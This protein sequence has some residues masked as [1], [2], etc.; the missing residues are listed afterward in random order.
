[1][2]RHANPLKALRRRMYSGARLI[3]DI[4]AIIDG[5]IMQRIFRRMSGR[6]ANKG[7]SGLFH[8]LFRDK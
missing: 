3:G 2:P 5:K 4:T 6:M 7:L 8:Q 1:M